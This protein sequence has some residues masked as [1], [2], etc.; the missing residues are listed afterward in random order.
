AQDA[1]IIIG[2]SLANLANTHVDSDDAPNLV[3]HIPEHTGPTG[4]N[5]STLGVDDP[6]TTTEV[7]SL[8]SNFEIETHNLSGFV[9]SVLDVSSLWGGINTFLNLLEQALRGKVFG[10]N[11]PLVGNKLKDGADLIDRIRTA[12]GGASGTTQDAIQQVLFN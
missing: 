9:S 6:L 8:G 3:P 5:N 4:S 7:A 12:L 2:G 10:V 1:L 11:L